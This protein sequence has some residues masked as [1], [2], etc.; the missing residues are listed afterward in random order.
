MDRHAVDHAVRH[1]EFD[2]LG[3]TGIVLAGYGPGS[4]DESHHNTVAHNHVHHIARLWWQSSGIF[5]SQSGHN[6][7]HDNLIHHTPYNGMTVT[8]PRPGIL[9]REVPRLT[10]GSHSARWEE[11]GDLPSDWWAHIGWKHARYNVIEHNEIHDAMEWLGDGNGL[12]LS[13]TG[14][15][16]IVRRNYVHDIPGTGTAAGIRN[17]DE[18]YFTLVEENVIWKI[19]AAGIITKNINMVEN[20][21]VV[22]CYGALEKGFCYISLRHRGPCNGTGI[23]RNILLRPADGHE[24]RRPFLEDSPLLADAAADD[25]L[26]WCAVCP[27]EAEAELRDHRGRNK[28]L[29]GI[30]ADPLFVDVGKG[31]FHLREGSPAHR[32]GFRDIGRWGIRSSAGPV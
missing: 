8:G 32:I 14:E 20:N 26:F 15:G 17:D 19:N 27:E 11:L 7:I 23:R 22:D 21:I 12:Y 5:I 18:Q 29:R 13:G 2:D 30:A 3:G 6:R 1:C 31:D 24:P 28:C 4:R 10:E 25:N 9:D 16:N